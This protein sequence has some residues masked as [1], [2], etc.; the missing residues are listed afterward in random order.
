MK[1]QIF[2][3]EG[4]AIEVKGEAGELVATAPFPS[5]PAFFWGDE[6]GKRYKAAYF[7]RFPGICYPR[8]DARGK[9]TIKTNQ[10][11]G[12]WHQ[13][14]YIRMDPT[15]QGI[16]FLGRSDGVLNPSGWCFLYA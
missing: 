13:G 12:I 4:E 9:G 3:D 16:Q 11:L 1:V 2:S 6:S 10:S 5:Q 15:T 14:D 7:E 8:F